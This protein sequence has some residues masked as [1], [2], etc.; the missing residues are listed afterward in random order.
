MASCLGAAVPDDHPIRPGVEARGVAEAVEVAPHRDQRLLDGVVGRIKVPQDPARDEVQPRGRVAREP[1]V[2]V[3]IARLRLLHQCDVHSP[4]P[5]SRPTTALTLSVDATG[6]VFHRT[7]DHTSVA[8]VQASSAG[9]SS[10]AS[11]WIVS[12]S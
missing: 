8:E 11:A 9:R 5:W 4:V 12:R 2:G 3:P 6:P 1:L 10:V 7:I